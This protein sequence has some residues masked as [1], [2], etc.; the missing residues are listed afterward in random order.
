[1][2]LERLNQAS[3]AMLNGVKNL[4]AA[5]TAG[6]VEMVTGFIVL[7]FLLR[8]GGKLA[9]RVI[10]LLPLPAR[11]LEALGAIAA[12]TIHA[13]IYGVAAVAAAQGLFMGIGVYFTHLPSPVLW[14]LTAAVFSVVPVMGTAAA[15]VPAS[16]LSFAS[17]HW[18]EGLF[19]LGWGAGL[20][21]LLDNIVRPWVVSEQVE[22]N[23]LLVFLSLLGGVATFG[24]AGVFLGPV[25][26]SLAS[27]LV[28][29]L[30][31]EMPLGER[32]D[33]P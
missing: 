21:A 32:E 15:W 11:Q 3:M 17:G 25:A 7:F 6:I 10:R 12:R 19:L 30:A 28:T 9:G 16:I 20:V 31:E 33:L 22:M 26:V 13:N 4:V 5:F 29:L 18:G 14:G 23:P 1:M 24:F 27:A 2:L 8:D